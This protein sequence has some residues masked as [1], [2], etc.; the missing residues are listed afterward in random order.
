[1]EEIPSKNQEV[2]KNAVSS[3]AVSTTPAS[4]VGEFD[5]LVKAEALMTFA[6]E[7]LKFPP[8]MGSIRLAGNSF[9]NQVHCEPNTATGMFL[10]HASSVIGLLQSDIKTALRSSFGSL[11]GPLYVT[12]W[13]KGR[14]GDAGT[15][16][17]GFASELTGGECRDSSSTVT[18]PVGEP[19]SPS[20]SSSLGSLGIKGGGRVEE[21][22]QWRSI[23]ETSASESE[24]QLG[25]RRRPT[26]FVLP[27]PALLVGYQDD[28][29]KTSASSQLWEK[30]PLEPYALQKHMTYCVICPDI[31][32]LA[33]AKP[34]FF[35]NNF[36]LVSVFKV[37]ERCK[38]GTH[39]PQSLKAAL[40]LLLDQLVII[41]CPSNGWDLDSARLAL[42]GPEE[43][44]IVSSTTPAATDKSA[45]IGIRPMPLLTAG[46]NEPKEIG[47]VLRNCEP[48]V[49][50][51]GTPEPETAE[52][53]VSDIE[54]AFYEVKLILEEFTLNL[55][56]YV[57]E[58]ME[59]QEG[60]MCK[61]LVA[62]NPQATSIPTPKLKN[63]SRLRTEH[64]VYELPDSHPLLNGLDKREPDDPSPYLLAI[65]TSGMQKIHYSGNYKSRIQSNYQKE[66]VGLKNQANSAMRKRAS[67]AII[68]CR[69]AMRGSF[70]L[71]DTYF[72]VNEMFAD[73]ESSLNP[74]DV[75][76]AWIWNLPRR[77]VY[78]GTS[79]PTI[80]KGLT[81]EGI[82]YCFWRAI[83][84]VKIIDN[85]WND[86]YNST[87]SSSEEEDYEPKPM[88]AAV[89]RFEKVRKSEKSDDAGSFGGGGGSEVTNMRIVVRHR[90]LA[91][92]V[93]AIKEYLEKAA[94][95][96]EQVSEILMTW[97]RNFSTWFF[98]PNGGFTWQMTNKRDD[99][100][101]HNLSSR[102]TEERR[103]TDPHLPPCATEYFPIHAA[104]PPLV[105]GND[106]SFSCSTIPT[107]GRWKLQPFLAPLKSSSEMP[108][109]ICYPASKGEKVA[110]D[111]YYDR[112]VY[113]SL[114]Y[115]FL[116]FEPEAEL[117]GILDEL[118][119]DLA[120][121]KKGKSLLEGADGKPKKNLNPEA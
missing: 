121:A 19:P 32:L 105:S 91:E 5:H 99:S 10:V 84:L 30:A 49:E 50:E 1:M 35:F 66:G 93:A 16:G 55:H 92:I 87:Y 85:T 73:H 103:C 106:C 119:T 101:V 23:Q 44:S 22:S 72:Q 88:P 7:L 107:V 117:E 46:R 17:D 71:N 18:L 65:W 97:I 53:T 41:F 116:T 94:T 40:H 26:L 31:D 68:P 38:L 86:H 64:Q 11:D 59:L 34:D 102:E 42:P 15:V 6:P 58:N 80:F 98:K 12:E 25:F 28:W 118:K 82:E 8:P 47:S 48:I 74:I 33:T 110:K 67:D 96:G 70:P 79:V 113:D 9:L 115:D 45:T 21:T 3:V 2:V 54:D 52:V 114:Q 63:V 20:Q 62:L 77:T 111:L 13:C 14:S 39:S 37:Y 89:A 78:F 60:D 100:E 112:K 29:L 109:S 120:Q 76:R 83:G 57:Q 69:T 95:A 24:Q 51:P 36:I 75:P 108:W 61:A 4:S 56:N 90:D 104:S 81:T 27:A 43:K